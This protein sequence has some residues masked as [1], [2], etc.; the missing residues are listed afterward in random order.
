MLGRAL[1]GEQNME[2]EKTLDSNGYIRIEE[3]CGAAITLSHE[4]DTADI[5][6]IYIP[7]DKRREGIGS[8]LLSAAKQEA[9][10]HDIRTIGARF[11]NGISGMKKLFE[12]AGF[13]VSEGAPIFTF[14]TEKL[15]ASKKV[16]NSLKKKS[17]KA[18]FVSFDHMKMKQWDGFFKLLSEHSIKLTSKDMV[19]FS[20]KTSGVV[21]DTEGE[22]RAYI[23]CT[24]GEG[25][26]HI[27]YLGTPKTG[28]SAY[29]MEA[30][31]G[32]INNL[33]LSGA[34]DSYP[35]VTAV[36]ANESATKLMKKVLPEEPEKIGAAM[37]AKKDISKESEIYM[38]IGDNAD[39]DLYYEWDHEIEK[40]PMQANI[41]WKTAHY[42]ERE[43]GAENGQ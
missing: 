10:R 34:H 12:K 31:K 23:F 14:D 18:D 41:S 6:S 24:E 4:N 9:Q 17:E 38:D 26:L 42:K 39:D 19:R 21:Y 1:A 25:Q 22:I 7:E 13:D 43:E 20:K 37:Y 15:L 16:I 27:D 8:S 2:F 3:K 40:V 30:L 33:I 32:M 29:V 36:C 35:E 28:D 11:S 5:L